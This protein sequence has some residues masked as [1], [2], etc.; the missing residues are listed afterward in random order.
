MELHKIL[1]SVLSA[2]QCYSNSNRNPSLLSFLVSTIS[3]G[4]FDFSDSYLCPTAM[5]FTC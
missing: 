5:K 3:A 2:K 1:H 4:C